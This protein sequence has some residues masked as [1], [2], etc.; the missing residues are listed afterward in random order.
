MFISQ[1]VR[2]VYHAWFISSTG[3]HSN[4]NLGG[5]QS[6]ARGRLEADFQENG[7]DSHFMAEVSER[8]IT[9]RKQACVN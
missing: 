3:M 2:E 1:G 8:Y 6:Q 5:L 9:I 4:L 7:T